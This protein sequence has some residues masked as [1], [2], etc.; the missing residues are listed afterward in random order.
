[1][2]RSEL[3]G[4]GASSFFLTSNTVIPER[5]LRGVSFSSNLVI[6]DR[7]LREVIRNP[8]FAAWCDCFTARIRKSRA[9]PQSNML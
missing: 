4:H 3:E 7:A 9:D 5:A 6:P 1:M 8:L 2:Q